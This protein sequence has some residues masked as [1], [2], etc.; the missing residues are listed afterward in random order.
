MDYDVTNES[1]AGYNKSPL[2]QLIIHEMFL[3]YFTVP[4]IFLREHHNGTP[5][6][7]G[8]CGGFTWHNLCTY[9]KKH[10]FTATTFENSAEVLKWWDS[11]LVESPP[12]APMHSGMH[13]VP[14]TERSKSHNLCATRLN[15]VPHP[16]LHVV[17]W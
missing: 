8:I 6:H 11:T 5:D 3:L 4:R 2:T 9:G 1:L 10:S 17:A 16:P 13:N 15:S 14:V 12:G 7:V